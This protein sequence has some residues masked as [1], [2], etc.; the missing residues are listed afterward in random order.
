M[1]SKKMSKFVHSTLDKLNLTLV[2]Q[3]T[4]SHF[5]CMHGGGGGGGGN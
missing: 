4:L 3:D 2:P 5:T 1:S